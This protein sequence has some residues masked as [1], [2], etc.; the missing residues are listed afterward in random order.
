[1]S[2]HEDAYAAQLARITEHQSRG[3]GARLRLFGL[4]HAAGVP[5]AEADEL[6]SRLEAGAVA[7]AHTW[8]AERSAPTGSPP[9]FDDGWFAGVQDT[10]RLLADIADRTAAQRDRAA[11]SL[12]LLARLRQP[13]PPPAAPP[14]RPA[15]AAAPGAPPPDPD[16]VLA[17]ALRCTW[18]LAAPEEFFDAEAARQIL[19]LGLSAV[20]EDERAGYP[21]R[22]QEFA[23][24]H[25]ERL[26]ALLRSHGPGS[27][28]AAH[29]RYALVGQ[30]E[31]LVLC[32]RLE[33]APM[34][35]CGLWEGELEDTAL[36]DLAY[37]WGV[38]GPR[39]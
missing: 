32:E 16:E 28:P 33:T 22:L 36:D 20:R 1:M 8:V 3:T 18:A 38:R 11:G 17:A 6:V 25:R 14:P 15:P 29:G 13:A 2:T 31:A 23:Q 26:A 27:A 12:E 30:P 19:T 4:L 10:C 24:A 21:R 5:A 37:A 35:L 34:L 7:G 39:R 9:A